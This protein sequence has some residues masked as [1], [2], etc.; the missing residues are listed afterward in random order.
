LVAKLMSLKIC[1]ILT[2]EDE[3]SFDSLNSSI[4]ANIPSVIRLK[5]YTSE[6]TLE[7]LKVRAEEGLAR[8]SYSEEILKKIADISKGNITLALNLLK[9]AALKAESEGKSSI[10]E[11]DIP[12]ISGNCS[13]KLSYDEG[14]IMSILK[15]FKTIPAGKLYEI[16]SK[17]TKY[18]KCERTFRSYMRRLCLKGFAKAL[19]DKKG[20]VYE[21]VEN[22][23]G[24]D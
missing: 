9:L 19:G 15:E 24:N 10:E 20:R 23:K 4:R 8:G 7:I 16:Y 11:N 5:P 12:K 18:P 14:I 21:V 17:R 2:S 22:V 1:V 6:Q 13:F 3:T